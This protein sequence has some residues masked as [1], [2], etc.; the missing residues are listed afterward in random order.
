MISLLQQLV[1]QFVC[2]IQTGAMLAVNLIIVGVGGAAAGILALLPNMPDLPDPPA[3]VVTALSHGD[4]YLP[5]TFIVAL[6]G[7]T[8]TLMLALWVV[9]IPLRWLKA[10]S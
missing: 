2:W 1:D 4:Y 6:L 8:A 3:D 9:K 5:V 10:D 7:T